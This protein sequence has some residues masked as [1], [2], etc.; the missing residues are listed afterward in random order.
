MIF[1]SDLLVRSLL[2]VHFE[3]DSRRDLGW[4]YCPIEWT[5]SREHQLEQDNKKP[6]MLAYS[7][8]GNAR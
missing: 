6:P 8:S 1:A 4:G 7:I 3:G 2:G 5:S